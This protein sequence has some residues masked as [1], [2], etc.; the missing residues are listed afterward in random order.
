M[1]LEDGSCKSVKSSNIRLATELDE[2]QTE[3]IVQDE[4][5]QVNPHVQ[6]LVPKSENVKQS[7]FRP[8]NA[9]NS[10]LDSNQSFAPTMFF[11]ESAPSMMNCKEETFKFMESGEIKTES[12]LEQKRT[13]S[14]TAKQASLKQ[15]VPLKGKNFYQSMDIALTAPSSDMK[16]SFPINNQEDSC[17]EVD[18]GNGQPDAIPEMK[19]TQPSLFV[20]ICSEKQNER[21][22]KEA[23]HASP[24]NEE[25]S[26]PMNLSV[27]VEG[28]DNE[29]DDQE[30]V[31]LP[32]Q[33][34]VKE[35]GQNVQFS[36]AKVKTNQTNSS[37]TIET[38]E[39]QAY[40]NID[41]DSVLVIT[42]NGK[43]V[44]HIQQSTML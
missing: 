18:F 17:D 26:Q 33:E 31:I 34:N 21:D 12:I 5:I 15:K 23:V 8:L 3:L 19:S 4:S 16:I 27:L 32:S 40:S 1:K 9:P 20:E 2:K 7:E 28:H 38:E 6:Q 39:K 10:C 35:E 29:G 25:S 41:E 30:D 22:T 36:Q 24:A 42:S 13:E 43:Q 37:A 14:A 11:T 44:F